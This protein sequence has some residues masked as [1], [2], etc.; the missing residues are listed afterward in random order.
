MD[1]NGINH[2][3][4]IR[5]LPLEIRAVQRHRRVLER[6]QPPVAVLRVP[7][8][9]RIHP[10]T[11]RPRL[12]RLRH[13]RR[14]HL[15][16][17]RALRRHVVDHPLPVLGPVGVARHAGAGVEQRGP[18]GGGRGAPLP[19]AA[20]VG[21]RVPVP[22]AGGAV[23]VGLVEPHD[24]GAFGEEIPA[25]GGERLAPDHWDEGGVGLG[26]DG[27]GEG[28][29]VN[30]RLCV[31]VPPKIHLATAEHRLQT[32]GAIVEARGSHPTFQGSSGRDRKSQGQLHG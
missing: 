26:L 24:V 18:P 28:G 7:G 3:P 17:P 22:V 27:G 32:G 16:R 20:A 4:T 19:G 2:I 12:R 6:L 30:L 8:H 5:C 23:L 15:P 10:H 11:A 25:P 1:L 13:R 29:V 9:R 14:H 21:R 31:P